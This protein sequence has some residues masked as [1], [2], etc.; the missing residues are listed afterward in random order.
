MNPTPTN[1]KTQIE[2]LDVTYGYPKRSQQ[3]FQ[4]FNHTFM[5]PVTILRGPS[6]CGKSTLLRLAAGYLPPSQG[7]ILTPENTP[8]NLTFQKT[9]L[10]FVFQQFNLLPLATVSRNLQIAAR[11]AGLSAKDSRDN[12]QHWL[13]ILGIA[14]YA[15]SL[16]GELS[17]GQVQRAALARALAKDP[18]VLLLDEPTSGLDLEN[19]S[20]FAEA[21]K[22]WLKPGKIALVSSHD[23]RLVNTA[24]E[25]FEMDSHLSA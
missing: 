7:K 2:F 14:E 11:F 18:Q 13:Q 19:T 10:G 15:D 3:V 20:I 5:A 25:I 1:L 23:P 24:D 12:T 16:P 9:Q 8:P 22:T 6:G 17:G 21:L 4:K